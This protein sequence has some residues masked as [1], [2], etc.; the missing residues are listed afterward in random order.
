MPQIT[1]PVDLLDIPEPPLPEEIEVPVVRLPAVPTASAYSKLRLRRR[2]SAPPVPAAAVTPPAQSTPESAPADNTAAPSLGS[3]SSG[4]DTSPRAQQEAAGLISAN[5]RRINALPIQKVEA[6]KVQLSKVR[7]F[8][9][10]AQDALKSGDTEGA[11]TLATKAKL[12]LDD[13]EKL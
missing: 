11:K 3:L 6:E 13:I 4:G 1:Q 2:R 7:N 8:Q 10:Q 12:L 9:K 5:E